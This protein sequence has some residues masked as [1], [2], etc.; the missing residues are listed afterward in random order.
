MRRLSGLL[1]VTLLLAAVGSHA[2]DV[3]IDDL[4]TLDGWTVVTSAGV[5]LD[6][7]RDI[8]YRGRGMRLDF[9]F[10][11]GGGYM[12]VQKK[13]SLDLP[14]SYAF[15]FYLRAQAL[16]NNLEFKLVDE[17]GKNVWWRNRRNLVFPT[18][19]QEMRVKSSQL[20]FAWG[21][22]G[23]A[24]MR[25][26]GAIE[27]TI[28]AGTGGKGSV[29]IDEI[30][31]EENGKPGNGLAPRVSASTSRDGHEP[32]RVLDDPST[33][34]WMSEP[35]A[36]PQWLQLDFGGKREFGGLAIDW[37][38]DDYATSYQVLTSND[39][40]HWNPAARTPPDRAGATISTCPI[41][42]RAISRLTSTKAV[43]SR[44]TASTPCR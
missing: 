43:E 5:H 17:A 34:G 18:K 6:L 24:P 11:G 4:E 37:D 12:N 14:E 1:A 10:E 20:E 7:V 42:S 30:H 44:A 36:H 25:R 41:P 23:G 27:F 26:V 22:S 9:D 39:G 13:F 15:S 31:F 21:P 29:W 35:I 40:R 33:I 3:V 8:G 2:E 19:W 28:A 16:P 32:E 38:A